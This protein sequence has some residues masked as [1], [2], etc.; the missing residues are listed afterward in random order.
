MKKFQYYSQLNQK[1]C[2]PTCLKMIARH[3]GKTIALAKITALSETTRM[4]STLA[5]VAEAA[6]RLGFRTLGVK[7]DFAKFSQEAPLPAL[8]H[9]QGN[10]YVV[11]YR[12]SATRVWVADPAH[13]LLQYTHAD[14]ITRWVG[15]NATP[16]TREGIALLLEP[17]PAFY[18]S[19]EDK[20]EGRFGWQLLRGHV[21]RYRS[22]FGQ[23]IVGLLA[24]SVLQLFFP[25]LTQSIIDVGIKNQDLN[26]IYIILAA[27]LFIFLGRSSLEI[28]RGWILLHLSARI[29]ISLISDFFIKLM[30]LPVSYFDTRLTGDIMQRINDHRRIER[31]LTTSSLSTL[32][33]AVNLVVFGA[34]LAWYN[35]Q[36]FAIFF[37][38]TALYMGWIL[39][40]LKKR[41]ELDYKR[42]ST[43]SAEQSKVIETIS[44][45][46][47]I[48]LHNAERQKRWSWEYLQARLFRVEIRSL[49][50]EQVQSV[51]STFLNELKNIFITVFSATLV[52]KGQL[53]LGMMLAIS[54][55][56]GQLN[57]PIS[58]LVEFIHSLQDASIA[59]ERLAEIHDKEEEDPDP[60]L[61]T[62]QVDTAAD[63]VLS[64][65]SF[66]YVGAPALVLRNVCLTIPAR[67][68]TAIV[69]A[70]GSGKST[71]LKLLLK[72][73]EPSSG[74]IRLGHTRLATISQP[75][76]R[77]HFGVV[78]QE[79][80][81]F[82]DT[83]AA[84][85]ALGHDD[86]DL[87]RLLQAAQVANIRA[88]I[89]GLPLSYN[90][91]IGSEGTGISTG[92]KQRLL[93]ARAI[94]KSPD[95]LFFDEATSALDAKN[96]RII[97]ENLQQYYLNKTVV[98]IAH[99]LSTVIHADQIVV[100]NDGEV[101]EVGTHEHLIR[102]QGVYYNLIKNQLELEKLDA[103]R[104][105]A[106]AHAT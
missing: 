75:A 54:Y 53:T 80:F 97:I 65:V 70:S 17:T 87:P 55:I 86:I 95:F 59:L 11:V 57:G 12:I 63:L 61:K 83:I 50:L 22:Y 48:K 20:A 3:H 44:G 29:N 93:I 74:D 62:H 21:R 81:L 89:E 49:K 19:S 101:V 38:S 69:G 96:E 41:H 34:V 42:F 102:Q 23:L 14:F 27:Q 79:G 82:N 105:P 64:E 51:G 104:L 1:D 15:H 52:I 72:M 88:F 46:Q 28:I 98:V 26:L 58:Q 90:T 66:R 5:G 7:I 32:F 68:V 78:Q 67:K 43:I 4:G 39:L 71:L 84:N 103:P 100:M 99:R 77:A 35:G 36:I 25:F 92:Q 91:R 106:P 45:M 9:W 33:S 13:G 8:L 10:H 30:K 94:Y 85:I 18:Q 40:F 47:E 31:L 16:T 2:G 37:V 24:A 6:E 73:Y 56:L 60:A 76:W